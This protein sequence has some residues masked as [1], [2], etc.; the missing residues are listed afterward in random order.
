MK[1]EKYLFDY[2][3][4][5][6]SV[7]SNFTFN[8]NKTIIEYKSN[9]PYFINEYWTSKQR[10]GH[11]IHEISYRACFKPQLAEFFIKHLSEIGGVVYDPFMGRG[12][13][14]IEAAINNRIPFG[15]DINPLSVALTKPRLNS[16]SY[17]EIFSKV[18]KIPWESFQ[19]Y[20]EEQLLAFYHPK[21]LAKIEGLKN[22]FLEKKELDATDE[23][24]R[25][26]AINRL[27]G[28]SKGFFSTY[29]LPPNQAVSV[30]RQL[31]INLKYN[32][33][34]Q[35]RDVTQIILRKTKQLLADGLVNAKE[36]KLLT[37]QS[38]DTRQIND[39]IISLTVTSPPF[40]DVINYE[41]DNWLRCWFLGISSNDINISQYKNIDEWQIFIAKTLKELARITK[42]G[43][44]IAFEVGEVRNATIM[45][46]DYVINAANGLGLETIGVMINQQ[47]FTKTSN[48]WGIGNNKSGTNSNRIIIFRK[49]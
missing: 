16:P 31:K 39:N 32:Q 1:I 30:Q 43:G 8:G 5:F 40:L 46:E 9:I 4:D 36:T 48:C 10:A 28:H 38:F 37:G 11:K 47:D 19:K 41:A 45:L 26:V 13:T 18:N 23:W 6:K 14:L 2:N 33:T 42:Q 49:I 20:K 25:M 22:W 29:T 3:E 34:P 27:T 44:Y 17:I 24:I 15:N 12:T 35:E 7:I 21:T